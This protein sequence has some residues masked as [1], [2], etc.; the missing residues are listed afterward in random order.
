MPQLPGPEALAPSEPGDHVL[1]AAIAAEAGELLVA[2]RLRGN[3]EGKPADLLKAEGD[4]K[5][6][7]LIMERLADRVAAGDTVLSEEGVDD[8]A[9]LDAQRVWIVDPL[10]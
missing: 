1:A 9:R 6:H 8:P 3:A 10:D 5:S 2:L 7:E 4:R